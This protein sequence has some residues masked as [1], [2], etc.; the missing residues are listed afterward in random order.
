[1]YSKKRNKI[2][3]IFAILVAWTA[4]ITWIIWGNGALTVEEIVITSKRIPTPFT[5]FRMVQVSDLHNCSFG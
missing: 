3:L 4:L 2:C 1:M 5:G